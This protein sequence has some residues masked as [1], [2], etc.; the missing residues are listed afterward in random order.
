MTNS[1]GP[2]SHPYLYELHG[3]INDGLRLPNQNMVPV[4]PTPAGRVVKDADDYYDWEPKVGDRVDTYLYQPP[5]RPDPE[6]PDQ[7]IH[8]HYLA[9]SDIMVRGPE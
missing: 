3:G 1:G 9:R 8:H 2:M 7:M 4:I 6:V 5:P